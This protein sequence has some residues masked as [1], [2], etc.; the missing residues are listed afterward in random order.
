MLQNKG[1]RSEF[2]GRGR[3]I[4][5]VLHGQKDELY[6]RSLFFDSLG[7]VQP[8]EAGHP[9]VYDHDIGTELDGILNHGASVRNHP[10][11]PTSTDQPP[12]TPTVGSWTDTE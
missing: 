12:H 10:L 6:F 3:K 7:R 5:I 9:D 2:Q 11:Q 1:D 8:I 4:G